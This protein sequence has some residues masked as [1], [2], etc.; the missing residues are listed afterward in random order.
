M[1]SGASGRGQAQQSSYS[2]YTQSIPAAVAYPVTVMASL[3]DRKQMIPGS[4]VS[5]D[6]IREALLTSFDLRGAPPAGPG[7]VI[8]EYESKVSGYSGE[9]V[10]LNSQTL[11]SSMGNSVKMRIRFEQP[12]VTLVVSSQPDTSTH[13]HMPPLNQSGGISPAA[14]H[15]GS[16]VSYPPAASTGINMAAVHAPYGI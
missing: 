10:P 16:S 14:L 9:W 4:W 8:I 13:S 7:S 2:S 5:P 15:S 1:N 11:L 12:P 6:Q 3:D